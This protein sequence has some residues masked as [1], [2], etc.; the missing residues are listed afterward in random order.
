MVLAV[1]G[2]PLEQRPL[3]RHRAQHRQ[4]R[5]HHTGRLEAAVGEQPVI[6]DGDPQPRERVGDRQHKQVLP[7]QAATHANHPPTPSAA[8]GPAKTSVRT[9][10]SRVSWSIGTISVALRSEL[11]QG[12]ATAPE[13]ATAPASGSRTRARLRTVPCVWSDVLI[14]G[15]LRTD[16]P[17]G[18]R[19]CL[20]PARKTCIGRR[21]AR[22][23]DRLLRL[24]TTLRESSS[25]TYVFHGLL[26]CAWRN[27]GPGPAVAQLQ[28]RG[29]NAESRSSSPAHTG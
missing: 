9:I 1:D 3:D 8:G 22:E 5:A 4:Q 19:S 23:H 10:R 26:I 13:L 20:D 18:E 28:A 15:L 29:T 6:A 25:S 11:C 27:I 17:S 2:H 21:S 24:G 14:S 12:A 7:M 16:P